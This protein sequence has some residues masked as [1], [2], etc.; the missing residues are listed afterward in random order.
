MHDAPPYR[1]KVSIIVPVYNDEAYIERCLESIRTQTLRDIEVIV[2]NDGSTDGSHS[3]IER[4]ATQDSRI[5][6]RLQANAGPSAARNAGLLLATGEYV[7]FV[8]S[9]DWIER[10]MYEELYRLVKRHDA[11]LG[12]CG[13]RDVL[14]DKFIVTSGKLEDESFSIK[15]MGLERFFMSK[16]DAIGVI[17]C[18]KIYRNAIIEQHRVRCE[19]NEHVFSEDILF[20][21]YY[22]LHCDKVACTTKV[23]YNYRI[24]PGS[25]TTSAKPGIEPR[26]INAAAYFHNR[27]RNENLLGSCNTFDAFF[28]LSMAGAAY[29]NAFRSN[30]NKVR[31]IVKAFRSI[32]GGSLYRERLKHAV[33]SRIPLSWRMKAIL[34]SIKPYWLA[35]LLTYV[36][37][38]LRGVGSGLMRTRTRNNALI[39]QLL[40][41]CD[42]AM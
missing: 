15:E 10:D 19:L 28:M 36:V 3:I 23:L 14:G 21:L 31:A 40:V 16:L 41:L 34:F 38:C 20:N 29:K 42:G 8:D 5:R 11:D 6:Y 22:H 39:L 25:L 2:I 37:F 32:A 26:M 9:D 18:N 17:Q 35:G 27:L 12:V 24:R 4:L 30:P 33:R 7:G 13:R 1:P